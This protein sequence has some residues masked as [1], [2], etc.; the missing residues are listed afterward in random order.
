MFLGKGSDLKAIHL[1]DVNGGSASCVE[2]K[3]SGIR[4]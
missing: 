3:K 4:A 1:E 2:G